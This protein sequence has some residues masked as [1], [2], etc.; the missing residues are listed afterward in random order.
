MN[1][2]MNILI[3]SNLKSAKYKSTLKLQHNI[4]NW[5]NPYKDNSTSMT[6]GSL[7]LNVS[8]GEVWYTVY[9][10]IYLSAGVVKCQL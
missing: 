3:S 1:P 8:Q 5:H 4:S 6:S 2:V 10:Y 9:T 7:Q